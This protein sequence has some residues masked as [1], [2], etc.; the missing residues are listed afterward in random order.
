MSV[1]GDRATVST[2]TPMY[3]EEECV[4]E[5]VRRADL[6]LQSLGRS[7][8][9]IVVSDGSKDST[10][11]KLRQ[12][13]ER[14]PA[15]R[16]FCLARNMGQ[17]AAIDAGIQQSRGKWVVVL[18]GDLQNRPEDIPTLI[19]HA[20]QGNDLVS[21][22]RCGRPESTLFRMVP[23]RMA[24]WLL[25][26]VTGC[27]VRDM[28]GFKCLRGDLARSLRLRAGQHRLLPAMVW[29][30]GGRVL[31]VDVN[32]APRFGGKSHYGLNRTLDVL[33]DI[34]MLW[35]QSSF[36]SRPMYL[37]GRIALVLLAIDA[38]IMPVLLYQ[39]LVHGIDMGT[40]PPFLIAVMLFLAA[41]FVLASG[42]VLELLSDAYNASVQARG[43]IIRESIEGRRDES[44]QETTDREGPLAAHTPSA[45]LITAPRSPAS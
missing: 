25:R 16:A 41:L 2:V 13:A 3:N 24:N 34:V 45:P 21:G 44:H 9:I 29:L 14:Y 30:R 43:W 20:E 35:F 36:K 38:I 31:E 1:V 12:L 18:D 26:R 33:I 39:R 8:E 5:F 28:G 27:P 40:R 37:F 19:A 11:S 10:E 22:R 23:S 4:E 15:L 7:Y 17:C 42:F 6:A 32:A